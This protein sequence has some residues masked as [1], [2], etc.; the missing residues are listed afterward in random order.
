MLA[1]VR[2]CA[3]KARAGSLGQK[4]PDADADPV[5][6]TARIFCFIQHKQLLTKKEQKKKKRKI[7]VTVMPTKLWTP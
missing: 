5:T 2:V 7:Q 3:G 1:S 6:H 4:G